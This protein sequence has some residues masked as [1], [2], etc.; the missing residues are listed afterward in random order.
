MSV[1]VQYRYR[2]VP[3]PV[4]VQYN[5]RRHD[6]A[7]ADTCQREAALLPTAAVVARGAASRRCVC[8]S[9]GVSQ[10]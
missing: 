8:T 7:H 10:D 6:K 3:V 1:P 4:P 5:V 9:V 2:P